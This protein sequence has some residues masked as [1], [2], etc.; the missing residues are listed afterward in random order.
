MIDRKQLLGDLKPLLK[1]IEAD[2]RARCDEV[3]EI[4]AGLKREYDAARDA[5]RVGFAFEQWRTDLITQVAVAWVLSCVFVRFLED[6]ALIAPP[7]ISGPLH[8]GG[9]GLQ[10]ARDERETYFKTHPKQTDRDYLLA[11]FGDLAKLPGGGV[12]ELFGSHNPALAPAYRDWLSGDAAQKLIDFFQ[13]IDADG[14]GDIIHDFTD[15]EWDTRFLGDLYQDLSEAARKKYALLQTPIFVE[16]FILER[17]LEPAIDVFG[18]KDLRMI[19]PTCG[20]RALLCSAAFAA[21]CWMRWLREGARRGRCGRTG[22]SRRSPAC[23]RRGRE[24]VRGGD[25]AVSAADRWRM[26]SRCHIHRCSGAGAERSK[27][28]LV[29]W[30]RFAVA[31]VVRRTRICCG[32]AIKFEAQRA[33][34]AKWE[35]VCDVCAR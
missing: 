29:A 5:G 12:Q 27:L 20:S 31:R 4:N 24:S 2:L 33:D 26:L 15:P 35:P 25:C 8:S 23:V 16:E 19:D 14:S 6:N 30:R 21:A 11:V 17:T 34:E 3:P 18:L 9:T 7:R 22:E 28:N 13:K 1:Q 32:R 10:R